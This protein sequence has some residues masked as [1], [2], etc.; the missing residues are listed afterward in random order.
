MS[1]YEA[2][3]KG[4]I[5]AGFAAQLL[6]AQVA[7]GFMLDPHGHQRLSVDEAMAAGLV[8]EELQE[9]LLNAE[10]AAKGYTDLATGHTISFQ[11]MKKKLLKQDLALRLLEVQ[12]A[13]GASWTRCT[14]T[15]FRWT[16]PTDAALWTRTR[17]HSLRS[18]S[19][20][21]KGLWIPTRRRR[22][23]TRSCRRGA[24]GKRARTGPC[25][26]GSAADGTPTSSTRQP[27]G[28]S[29]PSRWMSQWEGSRARD[30]RSGN[31]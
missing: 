6:E 30:H 10:N 26:P 13:T 18:R 9:R 11:A 27:E 21:I 20:C 16:R 31:C 7:T 29:K 5:P 12:V 2:S 22:G 15:G 17:T 14:T 1:I 8:G 19:A 28:P 24:T 3:R 23:L 25:S 4:L